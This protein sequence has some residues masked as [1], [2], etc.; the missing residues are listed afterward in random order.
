MKLHIDV[1]RLFPFILFRSSAQLAFWLAA[2]TGVAFLGSLFL[3]PH[4][5]LQAAIVGG[6]IGS[7]YIWIIRLPYELRIEP[8]D[9]SRSQS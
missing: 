6:I 4:G 8:I 9:I 2:V 1:K 7:L 3:D 5:E